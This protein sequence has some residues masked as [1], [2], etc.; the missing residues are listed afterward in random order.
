ML[1]ISR[2]GIKVEIVKH[3]RS[4][5][6]PLLQ[7]TSCDPAEYEH[8]EIG[9]GVRTRREQKATYSRSQVLEV[10]VR[11]NSVANDSP[12]KSMLQSTGPPQKLRREIRED[13]RPTVSLVQDSCFE[14]NAV[15][16]SSRTTRRGSVGARVVT[17]SDAVKP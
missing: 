9:V 12:K 15:V 11:L 14:D 1:D 16:N 7:A 13:G 6:R 3:H 8:A 17:S 5:R 4:V 10:R 2:A